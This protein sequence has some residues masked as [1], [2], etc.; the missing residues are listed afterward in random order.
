MDSYRARH[1]GCPIWRI[2]FFDVGRLMTAI[3]VRVFHGY[4][5]FHRDR[6]PK[7]GPYIVAANHQS[8]L[9]PILVGV[10]IAPGQFTPLARSSLFEHWLF[11]PIIAN[12]HS[13]PVRQGEGDTRA[14]K[15]MIAEVKAGR[16]ILVYPEGSRTFDGALQPFQRGVSLILRRAPAP[17]LPVAM[18]GAYDAWPRSSKRPRFGRRTW[19]A[20]GHPIPHEELMANGP[21]EAL[22]RLE[23]EIEQLR[24]ELRERLRKKTK[25]RYPAKGPGDRPFQHAEAD[26]EANPQAEVEPTPRAASNTNSEA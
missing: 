17:V 4:R 5:R 22:R 23:R 25:G 15:A 3:Y 8:Y 7:R 13:L 19:A 12:L 1:P 24:L 9:D 18:E 16:S 21:D 20:V 26:V 2:V 6:V 11:G 14:M 10:A